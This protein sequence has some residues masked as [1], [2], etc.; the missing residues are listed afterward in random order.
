M[1]IP[2]QMS[3]KLRVRTDNLGD[4]HQYELVCRL[5]ATYHR[6]IANKNARV[7]VQSEIDYRIKNG[8]WIKNDKETDELFLRLDKL[9]GLVPDPNP[10]HK[11]QPLQY[12]PVTVPNN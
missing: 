9:V 12:S 2:T 7:I 11:V 1:K 10:I 6:S 8:E 4:I 5:L 3:F